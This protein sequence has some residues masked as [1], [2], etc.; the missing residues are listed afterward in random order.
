MELWMS[1]IKIK[2]CLLFAAGFRGLRTDNKQTWLANTSGSS[3]AAIIPFRW[4]LYS[5][6]LVSEK[7]SNPILLTQGNL[8][9]KAQHS[10]A[11]I[12]FG[13]GASTWSCPRISMAS[14]ELSSSGIFSPFEAR[15]WTSDVRRWTSGLWQRNLMSKR[16]TSDEDRSSPIVQHLYEPHAT[17]SVLECWPCELA[18]RHPVLHL[19][20]RGMSS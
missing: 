7:C 15:R 13:A 18:G 6:S 14:E 17:P 8:T 4:G 2:T 16:L 10:A 9:L 20:V 1:W 5:G 11:F 19:F 3:G 12:L